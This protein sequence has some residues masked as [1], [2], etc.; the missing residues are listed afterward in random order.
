MNIVL[1]VIETQSLVLAGNLTLWLLIL[2]E[3]IAKQVYYHLFSCMM[4]EVHADI[5]SFCVC[6]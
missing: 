3:V 6:K 4:G 2:S 1:M 5:P